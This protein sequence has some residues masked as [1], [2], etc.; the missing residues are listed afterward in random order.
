MNMRIRRIIH[1]IISATVAAA[2]NPAYQWYMQKRLRNK[3]FTILCSNCIGGIIYHRLGLQF[4]SPTI[5]LWMKQRDCIKL[6]ANIDKYRIQQLQ[7]IETDYTYPVAMLDDITIYFNHSSDER[8]AADDWY[9]RMERINVDNVFVIIY[10]RE[11]LTD[12]E[13][14][15]LENLPCKAYMVLSDTGRPGINCVKKIKPS[16]KSNG[17]Q[18]LDRRWH[19]LHT[20]ETQFDFVKW[21]NQ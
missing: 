17:Q 8:S 18:F 3:D 4:R 20:F 19:G 13:I 10:D 2:V 16:G 6:A 21:L 11:S 15:Q 1:E 12:R 5:N 7:F 9:R 14:I